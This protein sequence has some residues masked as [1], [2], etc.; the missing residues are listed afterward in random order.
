MTRRDPDFEWRTPIEF[1]GKVL[2]QY[3]EAVG[4]ATVNLQW[5]ALGSTAKKTLTTDAG[6]A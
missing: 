1:Y 5:S 4:W 3:G 2:D 6:G